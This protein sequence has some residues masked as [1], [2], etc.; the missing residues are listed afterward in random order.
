MMQMAVS[1]SQAAHDQLAAN[2]VGVSDVA[3]LDWGHFVYFADP[4]GNKW[5]LQYL[6]NRPNGWGS[7]HCDQ[8]V[9]RVWSAG[10]QTGTVRDVHAGCVAEQEIQQTRGRLAPRPCRFV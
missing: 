2:G 1:D 8:Q 7:A 6:P 4:D 3:V 9:R 5:A 10:C